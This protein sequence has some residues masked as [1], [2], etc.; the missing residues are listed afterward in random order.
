MGIRQDIKLDRLL[1]LARLV[2]AYFGRELPGMIL[3]SG[4]LV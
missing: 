2:E 1:E 3:K 4:S